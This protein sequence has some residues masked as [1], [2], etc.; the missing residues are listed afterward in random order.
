MVL[1]FLSPRVNAQNVQ[2]DS[3]LI[4]AVNDTFLVETDRGLVLVR[5]D[6][7]PDF[8]V[9]EAACVNIIMPG[10]YQVFAGVGN[11]VGQLNESF[12]LTIRHQDGSVSGARNPNAGPYRVVQDFDNEKGEFGTKFDTIRDAGVFYLPG[13][14]NTIILNH[15][16]L[17]QDQY[18]DFV[19]PPG[20]EINA[21]NAESVHLFELDFT[22]IQDI[23]H[24]LNLSKSASFDTVQPGKQFSYSLQIENLGPNTSRNITLSDTIPEFLIVEESSFSIAPDSVTE[25]TSHTLLIWNLDSLDTDLMVDISYSARIEDSEFLPESPFEVLNTSAVT[26][27][28]DANLINNFASSTVVVDISHDLKL[29]KSASVDT[30][31]PGEQFSYSLKI[32]NLGPKTSRNITLS[33]TIPEFLIV[34]E[35]SFS[36]APDSVAEATGHT[37]LIWNLDSLDTDSAMDISYSARIEDSEFLPESPF[38]VVNT[39]AVTAEGDTNLINNFASNTVVVM[40]PILLTDISVSQFV[41]TDSFSVQ[42]T[43]T[44]WLVKPGDTFSFFINVT[45]Q[46]DVEAVNII[47]K[48]ILPDSVRAGNFASRDTLNW[49]LGNLRAFAD[50]SLSFEAA[51][52]SNAGAELA[53]LTNTVIVQAD[54]ED[55]Q[56]LGD[57]ISTATGTVYVMP[58][59]I[60]SESC[61]LLTL[62]FNVYEPQSGDPLGITFELNAS[63]KVQLDV[64]DMS[65]S[66]IM[67]LVENTFSEG[68][69]R[70]EWFGLTENGR[71]VGSGVYI[72]TMLSENLICWK[73]VI[74]RQ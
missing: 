36:I 45:N 59:E 66:H 8:M 7:G 9:V 29:S 5:T 10:F 40:T 54:N 17:I 26:A 74:I 58:P 46:S 69:N 23:R 61:E 34:E 48:D 15:Y 12:Y 14:L 33:D 24:D 53:E 27:E 51:L 71:K 67:K 57:N 68:T 6:K 73:K 28:G 47:L 11:S 4:K 52:S 72:I 38:E 31:Q 55:P 18:P 3:L 25:A 37:L 63:R 13:G 44:L 42:G 70:F 30:V 1:C 62:D 20:G 21:A 65:G 50:T 16:Y 64:Y 49:Q 2:C 56:K 41:K 32:E 19:N 22:F 60:I 43:D 35:S 39:S